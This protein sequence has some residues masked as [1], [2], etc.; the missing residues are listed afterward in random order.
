MEEGLSISALKWQKH[1]SASCGHL[2][3]FWIIIDFCQTPWPETEIREWEMITHSPTVRERERERERERRTKDHW[4]S[5]D[6]VM[7]GI[8]YSSYWKTS[9]VSQVKIYWKYLLVLWN[10]HRTNHLWSKVLLYL[11]SIHGFVFYS[12]SY[13]WSTLVWSRWSALW[14][15]IRRSTVAYAL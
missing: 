5:C 15:I 13:P 11:Y 7:F 12:F 2:P 4:L 8:T 6:H 10:T 1:T 3:T 14:H 9:L